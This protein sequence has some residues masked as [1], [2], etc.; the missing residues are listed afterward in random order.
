MSKKLILIIIIIASLTVS[1]VLFFVLEPTKFN[2]KKSSINN[3][4]GIMKGQI[5]EYVWEKSF[6]NYEYAYCHNGGYGTIVFTPEDSFIKFDYRIEF[7]D[8]INIE[9]YKDKTIS[10]KG[11]EIVK[12]KEIDV[13][14]DEM[15]QKPAEICENGNT[16]TLTC[17]K[18][19]DTVI[20]E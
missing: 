9:D 1:L 20:I 3:N 8:N 18:I 16:A 19:V 5:S 11:N 4:A 6:D 2:Y 10:I 17:K 15:G 13:D 12:Q 7:I 14:C